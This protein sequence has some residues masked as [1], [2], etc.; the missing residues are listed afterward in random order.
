MGRQSTYSDEV[1]RQ[2]CEHLAAGNSLTSFCVGE[3]R[4]NYGPVFGWL[5]TNEDFAQNYARAREVQAH[6]DADQ[7][8]DVRR[9]VADGTLSPDAARVIIDSL[10]WTAGRRAP[11]VYG[12]RLQVDSDALTS[13]A[14]SLA[15]AR[16]RAG[17]DGD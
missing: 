9:Q 2:I 3:G 4:P 17:G 5:A 11:K 1:G 16:K 12:D 14:G 10:K 15:E 8:A 7:Q 6:N 13:I